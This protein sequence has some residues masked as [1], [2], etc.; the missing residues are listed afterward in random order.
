MSEDKKPKKDLRARLGRTIAPNTPGAP[1]IAAPGGV[2]A[3]PAA[4]PAAVPAAAK[5]AASSPG[6]I[7]APA[8]AAPPV[9]APPV[10]APPIAAPSAK[11]PF[12]NDIAPPPFARPAP[13]AEAPKPEPRKRSAD[14]FAAGPASPDQV[15]LVIEERPTESAAATRAA[16]SRNLIVIAIGVVVGLVVGAG[17]GT[18]NGSRGLYNITVRDGHDVHEVF[19]TASTTITEA[20]QHLEA[21]SASASGAHPTVNYDEIAAL[22]A[23]ENPLHAGAF[24]RK[25]FNRFHPETVDDLFNYDHNVQALWEDFQ[26]LNAITSGPAR[27]ATLD[28]TAA[29][30]TCPAD[31]GHDEASATAAMQAALQAT[32]D[33]ANAQY[34]ALLQTA[35]DG[36]VQGTLGF[37]EQDLD[38]TSHAATGRTFMR[39]GRSGPGRAFDRWTPGATIGST[40]AFVIPIDGP[41]SVGVLGDRQGA[42]RVFAQSLE[43]TRALMHETIEIQQRLTTALTEIQNLQEEFAL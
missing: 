37:A 5:P 40:P 4:A 39:A 13:A 14:P 23:L 15:R 8:V 12:G 22:V 21:I 41:G 35:D 7:A 38:P 42:F 30:T 29:A 33:D 1:P 26:H 34:V 27:R 11:M 10:I 24:S 9:M 3:P 43:E 18:A 28:Q 17:A 19:T 36:T 32:S 6:E 31:L 16:Q 2:I 20:Q 25:N